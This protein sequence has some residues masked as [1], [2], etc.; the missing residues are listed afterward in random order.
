MEVRGGCP[1]SFP[2]ALAHNKCLAF[3]H[4]ESQAVLHWWLLLCRHFSL[5]QFLHPR[6][7]PNPC[8]GAGEGGLWGTESC[9]DEMERFSSSGLVYTIAKTSWNCS[10]GVCS[11]HQTW[12]EIPN[13]VYSFFL[14]SVYK[15]DMVAWFSAGRR[16]ISMLLSTYLSFDICINLF[17]EE[18]ST[19]VAS[20]LVIR[21]IGR[22]RIAV[23]CSSAVGFWANTR[24]LLLG[25]CFC[26]ASSID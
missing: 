15:A 1:W 22:E 7:C 3:L 11:R 24:F 16:R 12:K 21:H 10:F 20:G 4:R 13:W 9:G 5:P 8:P 14:I 2:P 6:L 26:S 19:K 17:S 23:G 18:L 25:E